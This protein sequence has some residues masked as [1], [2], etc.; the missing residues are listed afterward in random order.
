MNK[1]LNIGLN[2]LYMNR[3]LSG[4]SI[5]Y[6]IN[7]VNELVQID[8]KNN[9]TIYVN[10]DC[11]DLPIVLGPNFT[12]VI[13]PFHNK[14]VYV[15]YLWEQLIFPFY[16]I[17]KRLDVVHSLG[18][19]GP[20][21][22]WPKHLVSILDLNYK[23]HAESMSKSKKILL[24]A[25]VK[26]MSRVAKRIITISN[27]SKREISSGLNVNENLIDVTLLSG[28]NDKTNKE[29]SDFNPKQQYRIV[30]DYIIAFGSPSSHKNIMG[31]LAAFAEVVK[32][33]ENTTLVL[34]G[35]QHN[36]QELSEEIERLDLKGSVL[37]TGFVPDEHIYPLLKA[38]KLFIFP[39]FYEG[40]GIPL[41]DAQAVGVPVV[42]SNA[43][44]LPE[45]G[46]ESAVYF[47]PY[48][49]QEM[50]Q[51]IISV[52]DNEDLAK[53]LILKG[54]INRQ[55]FSWKNTAVNTLK[56]YEKYAVS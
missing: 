22:C 7:L 13:V 21:F 33:F 52:L 40:F 30:G 5:T 8:Q 25:M 2:L 20:I 42:S 11:T 51:A 6:G 43:A 9:Y 56:I 26:V 31:L 17:G 49:I 28:S 27:F 3:K 23:R 39:S 38:A 46:G 35:H 44:S 1:P 37:F 16:L 15:R 14:Y 54:T 50:S 10:K 41:L 4:G 19:V 24:G 45:V 36:N 48:Q 29:I 18:Y 32:S 47:D 55:K 12:V 53:E 34:V